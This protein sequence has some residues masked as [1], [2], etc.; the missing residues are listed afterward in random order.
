MTGLSLSFNPN[1][2]AGSPVGRDN[3]RVASSVQDQLPVARAGKLKLVVGAVHPHFPGKK[4]TAIVRSNARLSFCTRS[5]SHLLWTPVH[6]SVGD[7]NR[8]VVDCGKA[9]IGFPIDA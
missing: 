6:R 9:L 3:T 2:R 8:A 5:S 4:S 1:S 7:E